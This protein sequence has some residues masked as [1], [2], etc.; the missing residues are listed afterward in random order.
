[1]NTEDREKI[2]DIALAHISAKSNPTI[3]E[4]NERI[5]RRYYI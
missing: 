1:M 4:I 5:R 2:I 3:V